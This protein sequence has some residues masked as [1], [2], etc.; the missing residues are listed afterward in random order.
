MDKKEES[1]KKTSERVWKKNDELTIEITDMDT[2][3]NGIG[4]AKIKGEP[5]TQKGYTLFVK[6]AV[7]G[8][9][10]KV[11]IMKAKKNYGYAKLLEVV[12]ASRYRVEP[13]CPV[14]RQCGGCQLMSLSYKKQVELKENKIIRCLVGI[15]HMDEGEVLAKKDKFIAMK[16][17]YFYRNKALFPVGKGRNGACKIGFYAGHTHTIIDCPGCYLQGP[18]MMKTKEII[19]AVKKFVNLHGLSVYDE[20]TGTGLLRHVLVR[21]GFFTGEWMICLVINGVSFPGQE[22]LIE[23][24]SQIEGV[25]SICLNYNMEETNVVMGEHTT[26]LWGNPY[27]TDTIGETLYHISPVSF[28][29]VNPKQTINLYRSILEY[30]QLTGKETVW[31]L[32]CG[33]G[34]I[35]LFVARMAG[36]VY[37][38]EIN[39]QAIKDAKENADLNKI[40]NVTFYAGAAQDFVPSADETMLPKPD[41]II[42]DPPRKGCDIELL[43]TIVKAAPSR[44]VYVSCDPATL[45]RDLEM[46]C[47]NGFKL[48]HFRGCDMF[49]MTGHV[50]SVCL[51]SKLNVEHRIEVEM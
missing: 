51:L 13:A 11:K 32:Y 20:K 31:D 1:R 29:Q 26:L 46:L 10:C 24:I 16:E 22:L 33:I 5:E 48:E 28:F 4:H 47:N 49:G 34:T 41:V 42:V 30:A 35:S 50:E 27:I 44:L 21:S 39:P 3:G 6:D 38:V 12:R 25:S 37:G 7:I 23:E 17:P 9:K 8:D 19:E 2:E 15:G 14:A 40:E 36:W 18:D 45:A 43:N